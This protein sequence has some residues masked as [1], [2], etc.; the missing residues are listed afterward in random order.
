MHRAPRYWRWLRRVVVAVVV[1]PALAGAAWLAFLGWAPE[2]PP[3]LPAALAPEDVERPP[4]GSLP[5]PGP[6][7]YGDCVRI[8]SID[9]GGVRGLIPALILERIEQHTGK[10]ISEQFNLIVGTS[11]GS[12]LALGLTRP[13]DADARK[14]AFSARELVQLFKDNAAKI[15]PNNYALLRSVQQVFRPKYSAHGIESVFDRYFGDVRLFEALTSVAVPAYDIQNGRR[16]W[17]GD[18]AHSGLFMKDVA[19]GATAVPSYFPPVRLAVQKHAEESGYV[20]LVDGALFANNPAQEAL[21]FA[22]RLRSQEDGSL[23]LVSVGTGRGSRT[24]SFEAVWGWGTMG[25][26]DPLLE[27]ALSDPA[28]EFQTRRMMAMSGATYFRFQP[29]LGVNPLPLDASTPQAIDRLTKLTDKFLQEP[30]N[31]AAFERL[32]AELLLPRSPKCGKPIGQPYERPLG[33]RKR[34]G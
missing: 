13:G 22:Q 32:V 21:A 16:I 17:F 33:P 25:W 27:I 20:T 6:R 18:G 14:P 28:V 8:L 5:S 24:Y 34:P 11:T 19:R 15:F 3:P 9:G 30:E 29:D 10:A 1:I 26:L 2:R 7:H 12:I 4:W 23:L 31:K